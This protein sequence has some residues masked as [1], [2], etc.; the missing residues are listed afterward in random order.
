[1]SERQPD[2]DLR[3]L[4]QELREGDRERIPDFQ[5]MMA[6]AREE[7]SLAK[8]TPSARPPMRRRLAWGGSLL[9]AA[10]AAALLLIQMPHGGD[11]EF[12]RVVQA[13]ASDPATGAWKS[14]TD[15][16]MD[17]PGAEILSTVPSI[18]NRRWAR[19]AGDDPRRNEL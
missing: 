19:P 13:F 16:L 18:G 4:F 6:R 7:A 10:C 8:I 17:L 15:A 9:A 2:R 14:P 11:A 5:G 1:V 12:E 3:E